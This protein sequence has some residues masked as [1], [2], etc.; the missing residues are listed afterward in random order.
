MDE[1][2]KPLM[3]FEDRKVYELPEPAT[4][5][6]LP[7][8]RTYI[9]RRVAVLLGG[10]FIVHIALNPFASSLRTS[11]F[12]HDWLGHLH[13][14]RHHLTTT[15]DREAFFLSIPS[16]KSASD[17][18]VKL[19]SHPH[20]A[21]SDQDFTDAKF[22]LSV[23][24]NAL[25]L[26]KSGHCAHSKH[27][28]LPIYKAGSN[29]SRWA[30]HSLT[31]PSVA[32]KDRLPHAWIDVY[33]PVLNTPINGSLEILSEDGSSSEWVADLAEVGDP[34]DKDAEKYSDAIKAWHGLSK[35]GEAQGQLVYANYGTQEDYAELLSQG[36]DLK[37]KI[38]LTRYGGIF[39][40][41]KVKGAE[42]LGAFGALIYSDP[43]DDGSVTEENGYLPY[44]HGPARNPTSVQRGSVQYLSMYP[45]DPTTPGV[46][47]YENATRTEGENI[48]KIPSLPLS[49]L[50][51]QRLL[52][53]ISDDL[54]EARK[55]TGKASDKRIKL[56]NNVE[57]KVT[58]IWNT[59]AAI[60]GHIRNEVVVIGNHRDA[61]VLGAAD[62]ISGTASMLEIVRAFGELHKKGWQPMR[63]ILFASWDAEEYGLIGS[64]EWGE[65]FARWISK[66]VVTYLNGDT[67]SSGSRFGVQASP[68][69][70]HLIRQTAQ[71][72]D[73]P[74]EAG[75]SLWDARTDTGKFPAPAGHV[76]EQFETL[77]EGVRPLGSGSDYTVFLQRLGVASANAGFSSTLQDPVY[78]YHS[79]FDTQRFQELYADPGFHRHVAV[80]KFLGLL[81]LRI[82][83]SPI[84]ALD[85]TYYSH[86]LES[87]LESVE[88]L[89]SAA[90]LKDVDFSDLRHSIHK[91]Q[92]ASTHL[93]K[94]AS[95]A[96]RKL[97]K[98]VSQ[99]PGHIQI[100][101]STHCGLN[102]FSNKFNR[103][104][105]S[106]VT[107]FTPEK[108]E[109]LGMKPG[110]MDETVAWI[111]SAF[112]EQMKPSPDFNETVWSALDL[113]TPAER[114][115]LISEEHLRGFT[116]GFAPNDYKFPLEKFIKAAKRLGTA[117]K[118]IAAFEQGFISE[119]GIKGR[120]W[121]RHLGVA[122]GKWLGYGATTFPAITEALTIDKN[123][124]LAQQEADR[125]TKLIHELIKTIKV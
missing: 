34:L 91:L 41:L 24:E 103:W 1:E 30:T 84:I 82:V 62:P 55:L 80:S 76:E 93:Q 71:D 8:R 44:P 22:V 88:A 9:A 59:M 48:P 3:V 50:N 121:Y 100:A 47:S 72:L 14:H 40:G 21:G 65:D 19:A 53:E 68:S 2:S 57:T 102:Q 119:E 85:T 78:H 97:E 87:Y 17:F 118:K 112:R 67:S 32:G 60:P 23:F 107:A 109:A 26:K 125:L 101:S 63:T 124:T 115:K 106:S 4:T 31:D 70:A 13:S 15:A 35:G 79:V 61:W 122:P 20:I 123:A 16:E 27:P 37:G 46:P 49:W 39:R 66:H 99:L 90:H 104:V 74:T 38:V 98:L 110:E 25:G 12:G 10:L 94:E 92:K 7:S 33:Y 114:S 36:V 77:S 113:L 75:R 105:Q 29:E 54:G 6:P 5:A 43:R 45:G 18:S 89:A 117:N 86:E 95:T 51:A 81:A 96:L 73:H 11:I 116:T 42:E 111:G 56:V 64:T 58:P 83:D 120:E 28:E 108:Q 52:K 69:L